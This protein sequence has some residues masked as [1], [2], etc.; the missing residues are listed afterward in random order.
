MFSRVARGRALPVG[1]LATLTVAVALAAA[2]SNKSWNASVWRDTG[3]AI[4]FGGPH[5]AL[6]YDWLHDAPG[7]DQSLRKDSR[8]CF[9][10]WIS[11]YTHDGYLHTTPGSN[12]HAGYVLAKTL[13][14]VATAGEDP[15][16]DGMWR[17]VTDDVFNKQIVGDGLLGADAGVGQPAGALVGGDRPEGWQD[18]PLSVVEFALASR[19]LQENGAPQPAL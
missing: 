8:V 15:A 18:A 6:A 9:G 2:P 7:I 5:A 10:S 17:E 16:A 1:L 11:W 12:Y 14:A 3:Y 13:I 4:R 19:A